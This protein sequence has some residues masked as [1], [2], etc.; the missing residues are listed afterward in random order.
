MRKSVGKSAIEKI[1]EEELGLNMTFSP[2]KHAD[3]LNSSTSSE[4]DDSDSQ[5]NTEDDEE[6]EDSVNEAA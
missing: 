3:I 6:S 2:D 4:N 1:C 5:F